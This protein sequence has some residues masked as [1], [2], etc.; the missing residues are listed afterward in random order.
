MMTP[1][2][3]RFVA[4]HDC[5][6]GTIAYSSATCRQPRYRNQIFEGGV[7]IHDGDSAPDIYDELGK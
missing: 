6:A 7:L 1:A 2:D 5:V 3:A 4:T